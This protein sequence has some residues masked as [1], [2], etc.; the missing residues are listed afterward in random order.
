MVCFSIAV[1]SRNLLFNIFSLDPDRA[2]H[3]IC[4]HDFTYIPITEQV[5]RVLLGKTSRAVNDPSWNIVFQVV[6][7]DL[8]SKSVF[9]RPWGLTLLL[10]MLS[11]TAYSLKLPL[12]PDMRGGHVTTERLLKP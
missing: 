5:F 11:E 10:R 8:E 7:F 2:L 9:D 4:E 1:C 12:F 3:S 6:K